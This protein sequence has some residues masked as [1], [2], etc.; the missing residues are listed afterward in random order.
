MRNPVWDDTGLTPH[1][2]TVAWHYRAVRGACKAYVVQ[3]MHVV[4]AVKQTGTVARFLTS[5]RRAVRYMPLLS[6][7]IKV[8]Q[9]NRSFSVQIVAC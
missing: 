9:E 5:C 2:S 8:S 4:I 7:A 6:R 1:R 3:S